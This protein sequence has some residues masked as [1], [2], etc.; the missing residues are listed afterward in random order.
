MTALAA[1]AG[2][3]R[4][5]RAGD[6]LLTGGT[7]ADVF[8]WAEVAASPVASPDTV[9]DFSAA[10]ADDRLDL[11]AFGAAYVGVGR[12]LG[13]GEAA[14]GWTVRASILTVSLDGDGTADLAVRLHGVS[15]L[16]AAEFVL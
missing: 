12:L 14:A 15:G 9:R 1:A 4:S 8:R 13:D 16:T 7:G 2:T 6:D 3:T 5:I 11:S 10:T